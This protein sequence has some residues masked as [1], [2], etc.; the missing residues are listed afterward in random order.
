V[1]VDVKKPDDGELVG[2]I[3]IFVVFG[4][5]FPS[6]PSSEPAQYEILIFEKF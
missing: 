4:R 6:A 3:Y 1:K 2:V 5:S